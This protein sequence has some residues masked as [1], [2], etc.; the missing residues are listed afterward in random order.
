MKCFCQAS[1]IQ[2][3][4]T[5]NLSIL[6]YHA[7]I[8]TDLDTGIYNATNDPRVYAAS[9]KVGDPD[10]LSFHEAMFGND[11][12]HC[13]QAMQKEINQLIKQKTWEVI[14]QASVPIGTNGKPH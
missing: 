1:W 10:N 7:A 2:R 8:N 4:V 9:H 5:Y 13:I 11:A 14:P 6:A 12:D 3:I